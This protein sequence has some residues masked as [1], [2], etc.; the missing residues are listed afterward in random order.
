MSLG[1]PVSVNVIISICINSHSQ[2]FIQIQ[3]LIPFF[4]CAVIGIMD[5]RCGNHVPAVSYM[6]YGVCFSC[7]LFNVVRQFWQGDEECPKLRRGGEELRGIFSDL[8]KVC[9]SASNCLL[10]KLCFLIP[11]SQILS[12]Q[13][14]VPY[15]QYIT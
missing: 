1:Y 15:V 4:L 11:I 9:H 6:D 14:F 13:K 3:C 2:L 7:L 12:H 8:S 10:R 5:C